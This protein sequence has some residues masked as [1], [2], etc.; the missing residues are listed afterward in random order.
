MGI[1]DYDDKP[2]RCPRIGGDVIFKYC[3]TSGQP[4]CRTIIACWA[5]KID[6]GQF[7]ADNYTPELIQQGLARPE[8]GRIQTMIELAQKSKQTTNQQ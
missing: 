5:V 8:K 3:R 7:L 6:I 2:I 1:N 4:F